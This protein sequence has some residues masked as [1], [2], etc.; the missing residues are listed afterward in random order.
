MSTGGQDT[1]SRRLVEA[2]LSEEAD[3]N[4]VA[5]SKDS[6]SIGINLH[7]DVSSGATGRAPIH[8]VVISGLL[9]TE[10]SDSDEVHAVQVE[11]YGSDLQ[12]VAPMGT[13]NSEKEA[14][15]TH[16]SQCPAIRQ[17]LQVPCPEFDGK[18][19]N[20]QVWLRRFRV[21]ARHFGFLQAL[22]DDGRIDIGSS[23]SDM[24]LVQSGY[25][26]DQVAAARDAWYSLQTACSTTAYQALVQDLHSPKEM[27]DAILDHYRLEEGMEKHNLWKRLKRVEMGSDQHPVD[28]YMEFKAI[29]RRLGELDSP[30]RD[31]TVLRLFLERLP[32]EYNLEREAIE[33]DRDK[34]QA[35]ICWILRWGHECIRARRLEQPDGLGPSAADPFIREWDKNEGDERMG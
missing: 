22:G 26:S 20:F 24:D 2:G 29:A 23:K 4:S 5:G 14:I 27:Y 10:P 11:A 8:P 6:T 34:T 15:T 3:G 7:S 12:D 17:P 32:P 18:P 28:F 19:E 13:R 35:R 1:L 33:G 30:L 16:L 21:F 31:D 25:D 9:A